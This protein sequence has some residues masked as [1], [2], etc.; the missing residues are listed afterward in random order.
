[1]LGD[2]AS[3]EAKVLVVGNYEFSIMSGNNQELAGKIRQ[4]IQDQYTEV[5]KFENY[6]QFFNT[7][8]VF[9]RKY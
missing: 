5:A 4:L 9:K 7:I 2:L 6:G 1:M 8:L 3:G